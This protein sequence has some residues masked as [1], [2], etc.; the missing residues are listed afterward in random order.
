MGLMLFDI[1]INDLDDGIE[2]ILTKSADGTRLGGEVNT[3]EGKAI[4]W[5]DLHGPITGKE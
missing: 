5:R 3:S 2:S 4:L 1:F